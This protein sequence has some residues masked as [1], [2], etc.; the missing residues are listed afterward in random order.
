MAS[1][2]SVSP[3]V[4]IGAIVLIIGIAVFLLLRAANTPATTQE[5]VTIPPDVA[6]HIGGGVKPAPSPMAQQAQ[7]HH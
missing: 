1:S 5:S 2:K 3:V 7:Q 4:A 6:A